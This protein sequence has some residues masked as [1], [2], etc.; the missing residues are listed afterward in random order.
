MAKS[1]TNPN[2]EVEMTKTETSATTN[3]R[4]NDSSFELVSDLVLRIS[5]FGAKRP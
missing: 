4:L 5:S 1:E 3:L 2:P